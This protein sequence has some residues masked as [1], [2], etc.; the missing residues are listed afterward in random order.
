MKKL[1]SQ[2]TAV[3]FPRVHFGK[4]PNDLTHDP[5]I[6]P[7]IKVLFIIYDSH[8]PEKRLE[9]NPCTFVSQE[10]IGRESLGRSQ[11]AVSKATIEMKDIGWCT[12]LSLGKGRSNIVILHDRRWKRFTAKEKKNFIDLVKNQQGRHNHRL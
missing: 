5:T 2:Q 6:R 11:Q 8:C 9:K 12:I 4:A 7:L 10:R 1:S 3:F